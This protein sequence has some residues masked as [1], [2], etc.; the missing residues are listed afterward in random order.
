MAT[1]RA[2][3]LS[4]FGGPE[5]LQI[6]PFAIPQP[7]ENEVLARVTAASVNPVDY[8]FR[9]GKF[10]ASAARP[11]MAAMAIPAIMARPSPLVSAMVAADC[12][13][14]SIGF[15]SRGAK[16]RAIAPYAQTLAFV[17][18]LQANTVGSTLRPLTKL[19][20]S[21]RPR[22]RRSSVLAQKPKGDRQHNLHCPA[23]SAKV[24]WPVHRTKQLLTDQGEYPI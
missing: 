17:Q 6:D 16:S 1:S 12:I 21:K 13:R 7:Q 23:S 9:E 24:R 8:K 14:V 5:A 19:P 15:T 18:A 10:P 20:V 3:G 4:C 22:T 2:V 11:I